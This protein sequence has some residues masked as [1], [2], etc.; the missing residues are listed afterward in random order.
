[1][2]HVTV[3]FSWSNLGDDLYP[4]L[5]SLIFPFL[6][7][8]GLVPF[9]SSSFSLPFS[10]H[11]TK[12]FSSLPTSSLTGSVS[13]FSIVFFVSWLPHFTNT[14]AIPT[15]NAWC[16][17]IQ[18]LSIWFPRLSSSFTSCCY[19]QRK[20]VFMCSSCSFFLFFMI[21]IAPLFVPDHRIKTA[22]KPTKLVT[23][24]CLLFP[25]FFLLSVSNLK[26]PWEKAN[27]TIKCFGEKS[28]PSLSGSTIRDKFDHFL[29][30]F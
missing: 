22:N 10:F 26:T 20:R 30:F 14:K 21:T 16:V 17:S 19:S 23:V 29:S 4:R 13:S 6:C 3:P 1:M 11:L 12:Y 15:L 27:K 2:S 25:L 28:R 7:R 24:S 9:V 5:V 18:Y 8:S